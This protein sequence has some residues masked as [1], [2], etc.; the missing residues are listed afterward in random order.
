MWRESLL[1]RIPAVI[2]V[3]ALCLMMMLAAGIG[4]WV[5]LRHK[6]SSLLALVSEVGPVEDAVAIVLALLLALSF[7]M[8]EQRFDSRQSLVVSHANAV[9]TAFLR[10]AVL[11]DPDDRAYCQDQLRTYVDLSVAFAEAAHDDKALEAIGRQS[12]AIEFALSARVGAVARVEP[13]TANVALLTAVNDVIN[14]RNDRNAS[15]RIVVPAEVTLLLLFLCVVWGALAGYSYGI[16][17]NR[18]RA[19][20][21]IFSLVIALVVYVTLDFDRPRRGFLRLQA[22]NQS[23]IDLRE[24][25][26]PR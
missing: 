16:K 12:S 17:G 23:M 15:L 9:E 13:N 18:R 5:A 11:V 7:H 10:C 24:K 2:I 20:W 19:A 22:G 4:Y 26:R 6:R 21:A 3:S 8:A 14:R 25:L 1:Y